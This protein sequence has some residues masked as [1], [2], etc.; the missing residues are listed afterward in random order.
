MKLAFSKPTPNEADTR[1]LFN[2]FGRCGYKGLQL[3]AGQ[4]LPYL[5]APMRFLEAWGDKRGAASA[6]IVWGILDDVR[7]AM[8]FGAAVG[9]ERIVFC[10]RVSRAGLTAD[11]IRE[12]AGAMSELGKECLDR[13]IKLSL[14]HHFDQPLMYREDFELF[15]DAVA[16]DVVGL[17]VDTAHLV[18]SGVHDIA[19]VIHDFRHVIDNFH[20]KDFSDG[21]FQVL[22][23][24]S[25]DFAPV[26]DAIRKI[27]YDGWISADE[28]SG[29]DILDAMEQCYRFIKAGLAL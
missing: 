20:L 27:G 16:P 21:M 5:D 8:P 28:E 17:T 29:A 13:G 1:L 12:I 2:R 23:A 25:I 26:F 7:S 14:H 24:G 11:D 6:L 15:F 9:T 22:G 4:Y 18:K 10:H 19:G 3:K